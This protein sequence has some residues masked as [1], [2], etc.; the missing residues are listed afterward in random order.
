MDSNVV[1][2]NLR[3]GQLSGDREDGKFYNF[4]REREGVMDTQ[5]PQGEPHVIIRG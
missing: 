4:G 1:E 2:M 3:R 5:D